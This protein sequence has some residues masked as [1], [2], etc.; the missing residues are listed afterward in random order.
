MSRNYKQIMYTDR[1]RQAQVD[2]GTRVMA[3]RM[4]DADGGDDRLSDREKD[5]IAQRDGFYVATVNED[6]WPYLQYRGGPAGFL[7][8]LDD[9]T[10]AYADFRGNLQLL[11]TGNIHH[12]ERVSLFLMDYANRR[13]LKILARAEVISRLDDPDLLDRL[14][15]PD[16]AA[17]PERAIVLRVVA[18]DWNCPQHITPRYTLEEL[19]QLTQSTTIR[20]E[21]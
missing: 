11:S 15:D 19:E 13:R 4:A 10:L 14:H 12:E 1:V 8:I 6:G 2:A 3:Q 18:Y 5:F 16:Y 9:A 20:E 17:Q 7:R 21:S